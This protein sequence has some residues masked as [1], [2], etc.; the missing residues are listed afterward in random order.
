MIIGILL[1]TCAACNDGID[2][3]KPIFTGFDQSFAL[4][5]QASAGV[6]SE[7]KDTLMVEVLEI[8]DSRCPEDVVCIWAGYAYTKLALSLKDDETTVE[9]CIGECGDGPFRVT[10]TVRFE[11]ANEN[12]GVILKEINPYPS[13][14]NYKEEK[15]VKLEFIE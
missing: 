3:D 11:L 6:I 1:F 14:K 10:D 15:K 9:L 12:L 5:S 4:R 13:T 2:L 8:L 7:A